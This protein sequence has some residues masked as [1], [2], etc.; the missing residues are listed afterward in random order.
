MNPTRTSTLLTRRPLELRGFRLNAWAVL[1]C[2]GTFTALVGCG[3]SSSEPQC[4]G[5]TCPDAMENM[6][7]PPSAPAAPILPEP[8]DPSMMPG[9]QEEPMTS[10]PLEGGMMS[11][12]GAPTTPPAATGTPIVGDAAELLHLA[13]KFY[14]AQRSGDGANWLLGGAA[15]HMNDGETIATDLSGGWYDAGDH[16]KVT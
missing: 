2:A 6:S 12:G 16:L 1:G 13:V 8:M 9:N 5:A 7:P 10:L 14:G 3:S 4:P 15:C 11:P